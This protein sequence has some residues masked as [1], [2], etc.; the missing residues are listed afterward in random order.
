VTSPFFETPRL[1]V[2]PFAL[3]DLE[4]FVAYRAHP[5]VER[6]QSWSDYTIERG[7]ELIESMQQLRP[8]T[9]GRWY[10]FALEDRETGVLVGDVAFVVKEE[11]PREGEVGFSLAPENQGKGYASEGL[12]AVLDYGFVTL[13]LH[14]VTATTDALN[15][16]AAAL[17]ERVGM[18]REAHLH[19]NVFF[20]GAWGSEFLYAIL[21]REWVA[22]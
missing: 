12:R 17:L 4:A 20:K 14:R 16:P 8:G 6:Y 7:R 18:R 15:A 5:D 3:A 19:E 13:Q 11:E 1:L 22:N 10:Q 9:P 2:R 21:D